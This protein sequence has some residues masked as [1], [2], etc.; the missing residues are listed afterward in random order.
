MIIF[1]QVAFVGILSGIAI[2]S[3]IKSRERGFI[4]QDTGDLKKL[5]RAVQDMGHDTG[6]WPSKGNAADKLMAGVAFGPPAFN[7]LWD[8]SEP[9]AGLAATEG[10][11]PAW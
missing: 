5:Q 8:L 2:P 6:R 9:A 11:Y 10:N 7:E 3:Y 4:T 1:C